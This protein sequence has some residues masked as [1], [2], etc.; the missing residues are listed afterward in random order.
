MLTGADGLHLRKNRAPRAGRMPRDAEKKIRGKRAMVRRWL[1]S[2]K[3]CEV[4]PNFSVA[5]DVFKKSR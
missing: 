4:E 5:G 1:G 3:G 2:R